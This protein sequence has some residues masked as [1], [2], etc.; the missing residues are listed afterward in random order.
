MNCKKKSCWPRLWN[1]LCRKCK[2]I[3]ARCNITTIQLVTCPWKNNCLHKM[4]YLDYFKTVLL[5]I[6][7]C[8]YRRLKLTVNWTENAA[9]IFIYLA[10]VLFYNFN[11][12]FSLFFPMCTVQAFLSV[13]AFFLSQLLIQ[14]QVPHKQL[15]VVALWIRRL[16]DSRFDGV[17]ASRE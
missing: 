4:K 10:R 16:S 7:L 17:Y 13:W 1:A 6:F 14:I 15:F 12:S 5:E 9:N 8:L 3:S 2:Y 11:M